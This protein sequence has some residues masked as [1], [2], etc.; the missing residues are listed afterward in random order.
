MLTLILISFLVFSLWSLAK[1]VF[2]IS[3]LR[4]RWSY[5]TFNINSSVV[6]ISTTAVDSRHGSLKSE[7]FLAC[8][9]CFLSV[10]ESAVDVMNLEILH[11]SSYLN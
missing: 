8:F 5:L 9:D 11:L 4:I 3:I 7:Y 2:G 10:K 6:H 1:H